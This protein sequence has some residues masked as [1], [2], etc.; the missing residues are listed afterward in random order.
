MPDVSPSLLRRILRRVAGR[1]GTTQNDAV[2]QLEKT[3]SRLDKKVGLLA[4]RN[5]DDRLILRRLALLLDQGAAR[6]EDGTDTAS[7]ERRP[8]RLGSLHECTSYA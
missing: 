7:P 2:R 1:R 6:A 5:Q 8:R 3:L 4:K